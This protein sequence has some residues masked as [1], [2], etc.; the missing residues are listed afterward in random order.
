MDDARSN[1]ENTGLGLALVKTIAELRRQDRCDEHTAPGSCFSLICLSVTKA[2]STEQ[3]CNPGVKGLES[4]TVADNGLSADC[5]VIIMRQQPTFLILPAPRW[6]GSLFLRQF[7]A[8][9]DDRGLRLR[10]PCS[11]AR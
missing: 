11:V 8:D 9:R 6:R 7:I 10:R 1:A 4:S 5:Q 3:N 2:P